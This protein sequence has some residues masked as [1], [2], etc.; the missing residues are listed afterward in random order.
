M[1]RRMNMSIG[2]RA[3]ISSRE[4]TFFNAVPAEDGDPNTP[5]DLQFQDVS[6]HR[7][8]SYSQAKFDELYER[9]EIIF[10]DP[11]KQAAP[12][13][14]VQP[15]DDGEGCTGCAT[16]RDRR[17]RSALQALLKAFDDAPIAKTDVALQ[18][19]LDRRASDW[20]ADAGRMPKAGTFRRM[21][22]ECGEAGDRRLVYIADRRAGGPRKPRMHPVAEEVLWEK[23]ERYFTDPKINASDIHAAVVTDLAQRNRERADKGLTPISIPGRTTVWRMLTRHSDYNKTRTR[24][25]ARMAQ[26]LFK[27][28]KGKL[29]AKRIL[30]VVVMDHTV[31]DCFVVDDVLKIPVGRPWVTFMVDVCSREVLSFYISF[32]PPSVETAMACIRRAVRPKHHLQMRYPDVAPWPV[33][34]VPRTIVVDNAWEFTGRSFKDACEGAGISIEWA[35]VK[36]PEYKGV[37]ERFNGVFQVGVIHKLNGAVPYKPHK[38]AEYGIDPAAEAVLLLSD[39]ERLI[40]QYISEVYRNR[41][42]SGIKAVPAQVWS[43]GEAEEG[44]DYAHDLRGLDAALSKLAGTRVLNRKGIEFNNLTYSSE[45]V[46]DLLDRLLPVAPKRGTTTGS[47]KVKVKY[48]PE[49][50]SKIA[51]WNFRDNAYVEIPCISKRYAA[52]LSEHHH[53]ILSKYAKDLGLLF[54]TEEERCAAKVRLQEKID[55]LVNDRLIGTRRRAQRLRADPLAEGQGADVAP[56]ATSNIV[57]IETYS[58]RTRGE[59]VVKSRPKYPNRRKGRSTAP[60]KPKPSPPPP[61]PQEPLETDV[62]AG[63]DRQA[64]LDQF[65]QGGAE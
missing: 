22:R 7:I 61:L 43:V 10:W 32:T 20:P 29:E 31:L 58:M 14:P 41:F 49:D 21:L 16:C 54:S 12:Q 57:S 6:D 60:A 47:V 28:L 17:R 11:R 46:F 36:T 1:A 44:I 51:V 63:F 62:F 38:L 26:R 59:V 52:G 9:G 24:F 19:F 3:R 25:G 34:G 27:P 23:A 4:Y 48:W 5:H 65:R 35:P 50:L 8:V 56:D 2:Q 64:L 30:D 42:H 33:F 39:L 15:C 45:A 18:V 37:V 40:Y 13:A 55:S 53:Q